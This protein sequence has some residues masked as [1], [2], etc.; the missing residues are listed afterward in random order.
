M[1]SVFF[2]SP[3]GFFIPGADVLLSKQDLSSQLPSL[4]QTM[5]PGMHHRRLQMT[6]LSPLPVTNR[7]FLPRRLL[8]IHPPHPPILIRIPRLPNHPNRIRMH[9]TLIQKWCQHTPLIPSP[10]LIKLPRLLHMHTPALL[11][12]RTCPLKRLQPFTRFQHRTR[13]Q[14]LL[15]L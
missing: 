2:L 8:P 5:R 15:D 3:F 13:R 1:F 4:R 11:L 7:S 9:I 12:S 10:P 6:L 14:A